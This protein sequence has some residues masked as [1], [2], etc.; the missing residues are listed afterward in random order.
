MSCT[1]ARGQ[2]GDADVAMVGSAPDG[3]PPQQ[4]YPS[5]GVVVSPSALGLTALLASIISSKRSD[6]SSDVIG[7]SVVQDH[8]AW[9]DKCTDAF[10]KTFHERWQLLHLPESDKEVD[11]KLLTASTIL[12]GSWASDDEIM[13]P[14]ALRV[15]N[16]L[17]DRVFQEL[18]RA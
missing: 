5:P 12:L 13:R 10:E 15:H 2:G 1:F 16:A 18:V 8:R 3:A 4:S 7:N 17:V 9:V 11:N 14:M 6:Q